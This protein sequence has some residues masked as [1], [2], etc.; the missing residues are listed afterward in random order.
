MTLQEF[1]DKVSLLKAEGLQ[2][3]KENKLQEAEAKKQEIETLTA[4]FEAEKEKFA[5]E[6]V[7]NHGTDVPS[8]LQ[9]VQ[10]LGEE[11]ENMEKIYNASSEE[12]K[13]AFLKK[14]SGR[15]DQLTEM[16]NAAFIHTT[17]NTPNVLPTTMLNS[18]WDL[19]S[20]EHSIVADVT[21]YKTGTIL[22]VVKHTEIKVG[23]AVKQTKANE[24]KAPADDEQ[25]TFLKVTL[26][27]NDFAKAVEISYAEAEMSIEALEQY[28]I[29]EI[30][31]SLGDAIADDMVTTVTGG[32]ATANV[33][34]TA[35]AN[36]ITYADIAGTFGS[37][38]RAKDIVVYCTR[39]T[40]YNRLATLEDTE[41]H[42]IFVANANSGAEGHLLGAQ[43][44]IEDAVAD[45]VLLIG[46]PKKIVNNVVTDI[47]VET[48]KDIKAH[49]YIYSGY[50]RSECAL[51]DDKA[52][53]KLTVKSA[54]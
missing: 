51:I 28:L 12:Y 4:A 14:I 7:L 47:L 39:A 52:F 45:D 40:L 22:E 48:D 41:G 3:A 24:G 34:E 20:K 54:S 10:K 37:L 46:D 27:G 8:D 15:D 11:N 9:N 25:N 6:N 16:E 5:E 44:K 36:K 42:L 21:T 50:E 38:K 30:A 18:I 23:A 13:N 33:I 29:S 32:I 19:V 49:K 1:N 26:S 17:Q 43:I 53:A 35:A 31:S 2:L